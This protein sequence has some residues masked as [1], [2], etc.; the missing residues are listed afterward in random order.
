MIRIV[1]DSTANIPAAI[2]TE[3]NI[4][5]IPIHILFGSQTFLDG[6]TLTSSDFY[7]RLPEAAQL[8][9]TS[10]ASVEEHKAAYEKILAD[11]PDTTI[12]SIHISGALSGV[13]E[14]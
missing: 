11:N 8:P 2:L 14:S 3:L 5:V 6:V 10:Q 1:T 13:I 12:I 7:K 9:Q 4:H